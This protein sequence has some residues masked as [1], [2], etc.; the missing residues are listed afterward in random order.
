MLR[1]SQSINSEV[2]KEIDASLPD[3]VKFKPF[4]DEA[5]TVLIGEK[6]VCEVCDWLLGDV[7]AGMVL[8]DDVEGSNV[9]VFC[10]D[11]AL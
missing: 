1:R 7:D 10:D 8:L 11:D 2:R 9:A 4:L 3:V 6:T 5:E